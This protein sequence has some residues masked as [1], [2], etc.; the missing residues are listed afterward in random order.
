MLKHL[1]DSKFIS[2]IKVGQLLLTIFFNIIINAFF[3]IIYI[4]PRLLYYLYNTCFY[5]CIYFNMEYS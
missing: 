3:I 5:V 2:N 1:E 4:T